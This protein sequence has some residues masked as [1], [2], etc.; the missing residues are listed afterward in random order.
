MGDECVGHIES[1]AS[2]FGY[3]LTPASVVMKKK[4][5]KSEVGC[6]YVVRKVECGASVGMIAAG[7]DVFVS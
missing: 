2:L 7:K 3:I 6:N 1:R 5:K 4:K